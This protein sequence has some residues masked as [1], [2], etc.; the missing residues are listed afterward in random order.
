[1][2]LFFALAGLGTSASAFSGASLG[3]M[4]LILAVAAVGK[5]AGGAAGARV[6]GYGW[7]DSL[8]TG[9]LMNAR[10]LMELIVIKVGFDAGLIGPELFTMLLVMALVTTAIT[11]PLMT[12]VAGRVPEP[13]ASPETS[14]P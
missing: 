4:G 13:A 6:S 9:A 7:R 3:A 1:M 11:G 12:L 2:P 8:A 14:R 10:G 5:I